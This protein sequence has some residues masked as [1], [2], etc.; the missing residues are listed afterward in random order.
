MITL[1]LHPDV[2]AYVFGD[3]EEA[4]AGIVMPCQTHTCNVAEAEGRGGE[5]FPDTDALVTR[6]EGLMIGVRTADCVPL[7]LY[8]T[9]IREVAAVHAGWRGTL[10]GIAANT[11]AM[12]K[13][14]GA[15]ADNIYAVFGPA[16]C[17]ACYEVSPELAADFAETG[18]ESCVVRHDK[19]GNL[20]S[21]PHLDLVSA[22]ISRL[23][24]SG[25]PADNIRRSGYCTLHSCDEAGHPLFHSWRRT[26]GT[27]GRIVTAVRLRTQGQGL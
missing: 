14:H 8:A 20:L 15:C 10:G 18:L 1:E 3:V 13:E 24:Q 16:V 22:N 23:R 5:A 12:L 17:G 7:L 26:P 19:A 6:R 25:V 21:R 4:P 2:E 9:D 27:P 11:V